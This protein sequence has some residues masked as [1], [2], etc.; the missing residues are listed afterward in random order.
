[1]ETEIRPVAIAPGVIA[2]SIARGVR[3]LCLATL[4]GSGGFTRPADVDRVV[5]SLQLAAARLT[6]ILA[7]SEQWLDDAMKAGGVGHDLG[8]NPRDAVDAA[9]RWLSPALVDASTL[10]RSLDVAHQYTSHLTG[11]IPARGDR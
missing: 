5:A 8:Y 7:Q 9:R 6:Q 3:E 2:D 4:P 11:I 1:M 10:A